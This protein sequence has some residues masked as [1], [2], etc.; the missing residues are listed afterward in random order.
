[1]SFA[2]ATHEMITVKGNFNMPGLFRTDAAQ[3]PTE[4]HEDAEDSGQWLHSDFYGVALSHVYKMYEKMIEL[5][6]L[7][8]ESKE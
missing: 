4:G 7:D 1:M 5:G 6:E 8:D 3:W 2:A